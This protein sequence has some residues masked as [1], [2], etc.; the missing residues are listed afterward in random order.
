MEPSSLYNAQKELIVALLVFRLPPLVL[1]VLLAST[2]IKKDSLLHLKLALLAFS[3]FRAQHIL[4][5]LMER[6]E[7]HATPATIVLLVPLLKYHVVAE[8]MSLGTALQNANNVLRGTTAQP[9]PLPQ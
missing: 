8:H 6:K 9:V 7:G 1:L 2:A 5:L 3:A 4:S